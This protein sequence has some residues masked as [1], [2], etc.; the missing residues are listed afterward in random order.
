MSASAFSLVVTDLKPL[1]SIRM[2]G[3][4]VLPLVEGGKGVAITTGE[5]SGA[6]AAAG[7]VG[8]FSGVNA[9]S[10]DKDG[11]VIPQI[12]KGRTRRE[13]HEELVGQVVGVDV[14]QR[15]TVRAADRDVLGQVRGDRDGIGRRHVPQRQ[16]RALNAAPRE[17]LA[18]RRLEGER[19]KRRYARTQ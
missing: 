12:Y 15:L 1:N 11:R 2:S 16:A 17:P 8:T 6:W 13:R 19:G 14:E 18:A 7:G 9:D 3:R 5:C 4:D 10:Y